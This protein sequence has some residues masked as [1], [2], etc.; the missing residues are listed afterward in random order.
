MVTG[1]YSTNLAKVASENGLVLENMISKLGIR[2]GSRPDYKWGPK[3][4]PN[5]RIPRDFLRPQLTL[6]LP[7]YDLPGYPGYYINCDIDSEKEILPSVLDVIPVD[8]FATAVMHS[9][10][11]NGSRFLKGKFFPVGIDSDLTGATFNLPEIFKASIKL[12]MHSG[13]LLPQDIDKIKVKMFYGDL[14]VG[15]HTY[16][17]TTEN[18]ENVKPDSSNFDIVFD[19]DA[20]HFKNFI[21]YVPN[22]D[23]KI[24]FE[25]FKN[26]IR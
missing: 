4:Y 20:D 13:T 23:K 6:T 17:L 1:E 12:K 8:G 18:Y 5:I 22:E 19:L 21:S 7:H 15:S 26:D 3:F 11:D 9:P 10:A 2:D 14:D 24:K 16:T 25:V